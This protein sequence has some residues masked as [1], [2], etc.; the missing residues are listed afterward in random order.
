MKHALVAILLISSVLAAATQVASGQVRQLAEL[1]ASDGAAGDEFGFSVGVSGSTIAVGAALATVGVNAEQGAAYVFVGSRSDWTQVAKLTAS[2]GGA[3]DLFGDQIAISGDTVAVGSPRNNTLD[4]AVYIFVKP[5]SGW[6]DMT[7]TA[8]LTCAQ[9]PGFGLGGS[10]AMDGNTVVTGWGSGGGLPPSAFVFAQPKSGW[11]STNEPDASLDPQGII[12]FGDPV[13]INGR[14]IAVGT[15]AGDAGQGG[16][17]VFLEPPGGWHGMVERS[18]KLSASDVHAGDHF[19]AALAV[20]GNTIVAGTYGHDS[21][22]AVYVFVEPKTGWTNMT[23]TAELTVASRQK[24]V[25]GAQ[26]AIIGNAV[27]AGAP[28]DFIR[29]HKDQGAVFGYLQ[30]VGGWVN[31]SRPNISVT[32]LDGQAGDSFGDSVGLVPMI[33]VIGAG[34]HAVEGNLLQGAAYVFGQR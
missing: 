23:Q 2:D 9:R 17:V 33:A 3:G 12:G 20:G 13:A 21:S 16:A 14:T 28:G 10:L 8:K 24:M 7:E 5:P 32:S 27:A 29:G 18:A 26:V 30:P 15:D 6:V 22:G 34:G 19:G 25:L 31:T 4:G 1:T 11:A